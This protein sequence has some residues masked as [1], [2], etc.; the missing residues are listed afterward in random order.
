MPN[1]I[2]QIDRVKN[3]RI[4]IDCHSRYVLVDKIQILIL[5]R[6]IL[7]HFNVMNFT[8]Y[9]PATTYIVNQQFRCQHIRSNYV[10]ILLL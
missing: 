5:V 4:I 1:L 8:K 10:S 3:T 6:C 7:S 2:R 9:F